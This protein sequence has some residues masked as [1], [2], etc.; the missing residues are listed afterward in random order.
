MENEKFLSLQIDPREQTKSNPETKNNLNFFG[1]SKFIYNLFWN[2][3][4]LY[5]LNYP[6]TESDNNY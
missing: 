5:L 4:F 1:N 3:P 6:E 2:P